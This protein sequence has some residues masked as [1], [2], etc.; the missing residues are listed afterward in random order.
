MRSE[1][2]WVGSSSTSKSVSPC[3]AKIFSAA[4]KLK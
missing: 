1:P 4:M 3:S 2:P